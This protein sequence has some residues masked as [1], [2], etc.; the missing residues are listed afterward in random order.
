[1]LTNSATLAQNQARFREA[2]M[3]RDGARCVICGS[4]AAEAVHIMAAQLWDSGGYHPDN[5]ACLCN[6]HRR[7]ACTTELAV[8]NIRL[9]AGTAADFLPPQLYICSRWDRWGNPIMSDGRRGRGELFYDQEVQNWLALNGAIKLFKPWVRYPRTFV[10][11][12]SHSAGD[13]D[14]IMP[15]VDRLSN[16]PR[17]IV[18]EKMDGESVSLYSDH[19]HSR[20]L[21]KKD[22][23]SKVWLDQ[24]WF[25]FRDRIPAEWRICG[26]YLYVRHSV[27]YSDLPSYLLGFSVW[28]ELNICLDWDQTLIWFDR[29]G[30]CPVPVIYDGPFDPNAIEIAWRERCRAGSEGFVVRSADAFAY[31]DFRYFVGKFIRTGYTQ[32]Y[33]LAAGSGRNKMIANF[34]TTSTEAECFYPPASK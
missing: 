1:V 8:D 6:A 32:S 11:P 13:G 19:R 28:N 24:Y 12:W 4:K 16:C 2:V 25:R 21:S 9:A 17:V 18:T 34:L 15:G 7:M 20:S 26:E 22:H 3:Q 31:R 27:G 29:L 30:I 33:P 14:C 10:L 23:P 5:G